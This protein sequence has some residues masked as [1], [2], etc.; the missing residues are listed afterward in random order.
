MIDRAGPAP[1]LVIVKTDCNYLGWPEHRGKMW[2]SPPGPLFRAHRYGDLIARKLLNVEARRSWKRR[3]V[4]REYPVYEQRA[5]VPKGIWENPH[6]IVERFAAERR[7][8][9]YCCRHWLFLGR[10]EVHKMTMSPHPMVKAAATHT[11]L[12]EP[13]PEALREVRHSMG[14]D[15]GKFD[16][17]VV[18][19]DV[20]LYDVNRTPGASADPRNHTQTINTLAPGLFDLVG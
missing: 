6:L 18:D 13:V 4:L 1:G 3:R 9:M 16:Y 14:F 17:G 19:G 5:Q 2:S 10:A 7:G 15:F 12:T 8:S 11:T 20:V